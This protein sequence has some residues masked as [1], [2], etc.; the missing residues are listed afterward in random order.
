MK[1]KEE[2]K[3]LKEKV[4]ELRKELKELTLEE[5]KEVTGGIGGGEMIFVEPTDISDDTRENI[6][7]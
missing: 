7:P 6:R 2:L 3:R 5:L 4:D 1:T